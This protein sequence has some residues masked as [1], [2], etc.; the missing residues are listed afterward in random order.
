MERLTAARSAASVGGRS[1]ARRSGAAGLRAG[2]GVREHRHAA[3]SPVRMNGLSGAAVR[4][5]EDG[6]PTARSM[7]VA[8]QA[9]AADQ[10]GDRPAFFFDLAC[11][12]SYLA[13]ERV[14]R[15]LGDIEW[16]PTPS[17]A[18]S[19]SVSDVQRDAVVMRASTIAQAARL[20]LVWPDNFPAAVPRAMR[21]ALYAAE[22]GAGARFAV[23]ASRMAFCGGFDLEKP[24]VLA[25]VAS[26]A[27]IPA[28]ECL[29]AAAE[30]WRDEELQATAS[31]L[32][33][34][35]IL[36]LPVVGV[37]GRW[38]DGVGGLLEAA[39]WLRRD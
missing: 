36:E 18:L 12:F 39:S 31:S 14:E 2:A 28:R 19:S 22:I 27:N 4:L 10:S 3:G 6:R 38:F 17:E 30:D 20:P 34:H 5:D 11:P 1:T 32:S 8:D 37:K 15:T 7:R 13:A 26:A 33:T 29:A 23:A 9:E 16:V 24:S 35:G 25:D 21:A